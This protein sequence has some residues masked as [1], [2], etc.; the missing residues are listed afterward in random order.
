MP[1]ERRSDIM[2][3]GSIK[4]MIYVPVCSQ[5]VDDSDLENVTPVWNPVSIYPLHGTR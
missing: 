1:M 5:V 2:S 3:I 4:S